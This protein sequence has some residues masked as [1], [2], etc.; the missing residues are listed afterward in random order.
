[1]RKE[2]YNA[3]DVKRCAEAN[4]VFSQEKLQRRDEG[5]RYTGMPKIK[6]IVNDAGWR[7][8]IM[9]PLWFTEPC[10]RIRVYEW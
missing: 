6:Q 5:G 7:A 8:V 10:K 3:G 4:G 9:G 2:R 1:M